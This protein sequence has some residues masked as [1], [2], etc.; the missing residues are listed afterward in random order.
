MPA[1]ATLP[2]SPTSDA[3]THARL[4]AA[5]SRLP[6][7]FEPNVG[8]APSAV[9]YLARAGSYNLCLTDSDV[10]LDLTQGRVRKTADT[11]PQT[12]VHAQLRL[13]LDHARPHPVMRAERKQG[14]VSNYF[15]GSDR[16]K[17][18]RNVANYAAVRYMGVYPGIDWIVYGNPQQLEYDLVV[19]PEADP[20]QIRLNVEGADHLSVDDN[21]DLLIEL[22]G[23]T[24]RQLKPV[25]YQDTASG[26]RNTLAGHYVVD[27]ELRQVAI[28]VEDYDHSRPLVIDPVL[29]YSTYLGG[30]GNDGA[31]AI[32]IDSAGNIYVTGGTES[33]D[34]PTSNP[35]QAANA[36]GSDVF[37]AKLNY[38][39]TALVYST[40]IGG[41]N[42]GAYDEG[43]ALAVD[44]AG[45]AYVAGL[46]SSNDFPTVNAVQATY[47]GSGGFGGDAFIA[48]L[49]RNGN[50]L[51]YSTF[52][53][54]TGP[55]VATAIAVDAA[56]NAY[57]GGS[58]ASTD[59]P[60]VHPLQPAYGGG[61]ALKVPGDGFV[62][63][64]GSAGNRLIYSTYL[65]GSGD[66]G[67]NAI[68]V[69][70]AGNAYVAGRTN[71]F[72]F[73]TANPLQAVN[74]GGIDDAF[75]TK[76]DQRGR[77]LVYSTYLGG[78]DDDEAYAM[79]VDVAGNAYIAG[80]TG[81]ANFP[82]VNPLQSALAGGDR[83]AFVA[84]I[85]R[86]G[87]KL[88][89]STYLGGSYYDEAHAI[90]VDATGNAYVA[91]YTSSA[92]FPTVQPLQAV[93]AGGYQ[94]AFVAKLNRSGSAL[95]YST[96]LGGSGDEAAA[97]IAV[98]LAGNAY[99]AGHTDSIDFP[100]ARAIRATNAGGIDAFVAKLS[101]R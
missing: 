30:S 68:A 50:A 7:R 72:D 3:E 85:D 79:A 40:Y 48:K 29:A 54:G 4:A 60:T 94:D 58:T 16:S 32:A 45:N 97:G 99:V 28:A 13:S 92:D 18:R 20:T 95:M 71:S 56:G 24:L 81:S 17:W 11:K 38:G 22:K 33:P 43:Y 86:G 84:K 73:P 101:S 2:S 46:T 52:L 49:N 25:I 88:A 67:L 98:D 59:F 6:T 93:F 9:K 57:V 42:F 12:I 19:A 1:P 90:A 77:R 10:L 55:D 51:A 80:Y 44:R 70:L 21:G 14:S 53:G 100:T 65:G 41:A 8:Q 36:G 89:Y 61:T 27:Q 83:D 69:D 35:L 74:A 39:G 91:G 23:R 62:A 63:K 96:Y 75:V 5:Y 64:L 26:A 76:I 37:I 15:I 87:N 34:F 82:T 66:D 78:N 31:N 47:K